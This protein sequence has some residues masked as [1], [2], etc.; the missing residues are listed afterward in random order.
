MTSLLKL[1]KEDTPMINYLKNRY[2]SDDGE[3][4]LNDTDSNAGQ[5]KCVIRPEIENGKIA[6]FAVVDASPSILAISQ[7][8]K[9]DVIGKRITDVFPLAKND[10]YCQKCLNVFKTGT[11]Y[12]EYYFVEKNKKKRQFLHEI[13]KLSDLILINNT[14]VT[15]EYELKEYY[16]KE[17]DIHERLSNIARIGGWYLDLKTNKIYWSKVTKQIHEVPDN[18]EP[19]LNSGI[20]FYKEGQSRE[21]ITECVNKCLKEGLPFDVELQIITNNGTELWVNAIGAAEYENGIITGM[22]GTFQDIDEKVRL[23]QEKAE[24]DLYYKSLFESNPDSV[25][26][27]DE[28][29]T[30]IDHNNVLNELLECDNDTIKDAETFVPF[31]HPDDLQDT[32][33]YLKKVFE[34]YKQ[35]YQLRV[36]SHKGHLKHVNVTSMPIK[37]NGTVVSVYVIVK[38]ITEEQRNLEELINS[39][40]I[41]QAFFNSTQE[42]IVIFTPDCRIRAFNNTFA[43]KSK[44]LINK[45]PKP[46]DSILDYISPGREEY[47]NTHLPKALNGEKIW[48]EASVDYGDRTIWWDVNYTPLF[49][50]KN[51]VTLVAFTTLDITNRKHAEE[52]VAASK[53]RL[54]IAA[55][56]AG[57]GV[58][59]YILSENTLIW[60]DNMYKHYDVEK[61]EFEGV[62]E[63]WSNRVHKDDLEEANRKFEEAVK[64]SAPLDMVFRIVTKSGTIKYTKAIAEVKHETG[65]PTSMIGINYDVTNEVK[66]KEEKEKLIAELIEHNTDLKQFS[67][68]ASHNLRAPLTNLLSISDLVERETLT[69]DNLE[70]FDGLTASTNQLNETL[71][72]LIEVLF[73]KENKSL[74]INTVSISECLEVAKKSLNVLIQECGA[75]INTDFSETE[76]IHFSQSYMESIFLNLLSNA[77]KYRSYERDLVVDVQTK[78][79]DGNVML[80]FTDNGIGMDIEKVREKIFNLYQRFHDRP[81]SK[82]LG[83]YLVKT[84]VEACGGTIS[85]DSKENVGTTFT[86]TLKK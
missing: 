26:L 24:R 3:A 48:Y 9:E 33:D 5:I 61:D 16:R 28:N 11:T 58:W 39:T 60:D 12:T 10:D 21:I 32:F 84:Q 18:F 42:S 29:G 15:G 23:E 34:G 2:A 81:D 64:N 30:I 43:E 17:L 37:I 83:L 51:E 44:A 71:N 1:Q 86:I 35:E 50:E 56:A 38:D 68:I 31:C 22:S 7:L 69:E 20:N 79:K 52:Q 66:A 77:I 53:E 78:V 25:V 27:L 72:D 36:I 8:K 80:T 73:I 67:Y 70:L 6:G 54:K 85:V 74:E 59:E 13:S 19:D 75:T 82:G 49:N 4:M 63:A 57:F 62:F 76:T 47:F 14:D 46:G 40:N 55:D 41:L 45:D 65:K